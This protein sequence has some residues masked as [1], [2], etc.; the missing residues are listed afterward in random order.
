MRQ[1]AATKFCRSDNDFHITHEAIC[2]SNLSQRRVA[3]I[4]RIVCLGLNDGSSKD[5][6]HFDDQSYQVVFL[7][8]LAVFSKRNRK[9]VLRVSIGLYKHSWKFGRSRKSCVAFLVLPILG[10]PGA[11][12]RDDAIFSS[13]S[14]L[15]ELKSSSA[16]LEVNF[17]PKISHRPG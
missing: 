6:L 16:V 1:I 15:Q 4:C 5:N 9:H 2:C 12:S 7:F 8:L 14:L 17:R 11:T 10:D 3:A 13:E